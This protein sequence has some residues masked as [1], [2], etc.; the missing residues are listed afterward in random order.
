[1]YSY[2]DGMTFS[3]KK[4][5]IV[6]IGGILAL[7]DAALAERFYVK[8]ILMEGFKTYGG[9]AGRDLEAIAAGLVEVQSEDYLRYR[10]GQVAAL[11]HQLIGPAYQW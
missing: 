4:D 7:N 6:N 11:G 5:A 1:M 9:L 10:I 3:A 8:Q 2:A